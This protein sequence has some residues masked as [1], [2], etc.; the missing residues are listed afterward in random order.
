MCTHPRPRRRQRGGNRRPHAESPRR[1][2][3]RDATRFDARSAGWRNVLALLR[4]GPRGRGHRRRLPSQLL[5]GRRLRRCTPATGRPGPTRTDGRGASTARSIRVVFSEVAKPNA[6]CK[7]RRR[8]RASA[9]IC[10]TRHR[11]YRRLRRSIGIRPRCLASRAFPGSST[12]GSTAA[13]RRR[14]RRLAPPPRAA[15][16][17]DAGFLEPPRGRR[18]RR[19]RLR[20]EAECDSVSK[21]NPARARCFSSALDAQLHRRFVEAPWTC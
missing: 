3:A 4:R 19:P 11:V 2:C 15:I 21:R 6:P 16:A 5:A 20:N 18:W 17:A 9:R 14:R 13:A 8:S 12:P 10:L 1:W 7:I